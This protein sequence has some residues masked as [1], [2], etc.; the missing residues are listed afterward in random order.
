MHLTGKDLTMPCTNATSP[1][2]LRMN[3]RELLSLDADSGRVVCESGTLW[4]TQ[5][6]D[7]R[8]IVLDPGESFTPA[9]GRRAIVYAL[10][11]A[12]LTVLGA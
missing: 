3:K 12:A 11:P 5:D 9:A 4:I 2:R 10:G 8:D 7:A 6:R 1:L